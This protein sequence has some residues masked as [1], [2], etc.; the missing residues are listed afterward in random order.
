METSFQQQ[1]SFCTPHHLSCQG[2]VLC[3]IA[4]QLP[5]GGDWS[6]RQAAQPSTGQ[7]GCNSACSIIFHCGHARIIALFSVVWLLVVMYE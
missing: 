3:T 4:E 6:R 1:Q 7:S 5:S 2:A